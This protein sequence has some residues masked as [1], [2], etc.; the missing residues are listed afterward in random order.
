MLDT[1]ECDICDRSF[2]VKM[3]QVPHCC[4]FCVNEGVRFYGTVEAVEEI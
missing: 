3:E 1:Y 4:P 2:A